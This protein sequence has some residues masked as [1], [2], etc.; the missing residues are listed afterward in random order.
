MWC[1]NPFAF[2]PGPVTFWTTVIYLAIAVPLIF[3][4]ETVPPAP[5]NHSVYRDIDLDE[6][7]LDLQNVTAAFHPYNSHNND[8]VRGFYVARVKEMLGQRNVTYT[9]DRSGGVP[10]HMIP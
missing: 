5:A 8:E 10:W 2:R 1:Q 3:V 6:A 4:H 9:T 7:W